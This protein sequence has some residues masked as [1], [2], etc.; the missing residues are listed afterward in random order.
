MAPRLDRLGCSPRGNR[1]HP[2]RS[3]P[4]PAVTIVPEGS[5]GPR[6][7]RPSHSGLEEEGGRPSVVH[8]ASMQ[9]GPLTLKN[10]PRRRVVGV[11][12]MLTCLLM[13][14][15][16]HMS[17]AVM[18]EMPVVSRMMMGVSVVLVVVIGVGVVVGVGQVVV[19][20]AGGGGVRMAVIV[21]SRSRVP[22]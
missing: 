16:I 7:G 9:M 4:L 8:T 11:P 1:P 14:A 18:V 5:R 21:M 19:L 17:T 10:H 12:L 13:I 2:L 3:L 15:R 6:A 22:P 20:V